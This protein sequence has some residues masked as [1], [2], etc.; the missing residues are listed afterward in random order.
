MCDDASLGQPTLSLSSCSCSGAAPAKNFTYLMF[1]IIFTW[2][3]HLNSTKKLLK[4]PPEACKTQCETL[5]KGVDPLV[6]QFSP[7]RAELSG[8][9]ALSFMCLRNLSNLKPPLYLTFAS[10]A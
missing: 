7:H 4:L 3:L 9:L 8:L 5:G 2:G 10:S 6:L 1:I